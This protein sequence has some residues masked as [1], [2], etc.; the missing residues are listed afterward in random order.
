MNS[1]QQASIDE[2]VQLL[3][4]E[5]V[6]FNTATEPLNLGR[7]AA[8]LTEIVARHLRP[9]AEEQVKSSG[10]LSPDDCRE[11]AERMMNAGIADYCRNKRL[12]IEAAKDLI[13]MKDPWSMLVML[14]VDQA[15]YSRLAK[16]PTKTEEEAAH[17]F[18]IHR[19]DQCEEPNRVPRP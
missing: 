10:W 16:L 3:K 2:I 9:V 19:R 11:R 1:H 17:R 7:V 13:L 14:G 4:R 15:H 5:Q 18:H 6:F 12:A 8:D